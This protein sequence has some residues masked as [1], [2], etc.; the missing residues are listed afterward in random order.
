M[1]CTHV[2][3]GIECGNNEV[4]K[5]VLKRNTS[6]ERII[7][8]V[9]ILKKNKI[10]LM[11]QNL[12]GLPIPNPTKVDFDTLD[13]NIKLKPHFGWASILYPYPGTEIGSLAT[14]VGYFDGNF[15]GNLVGYFDGNFVGNFDGYWDVPKCFIPIIPFDGSSSEGDV[16][17]LMFLCSPFLIIPIST[18]SPTPNSIS[19]KSCGDLIL[20]PF[21]SVIISW[22]NYDEA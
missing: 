3:M 6:N 18:D 16:I 10:K 8:A 1:N 15:V 5:K 2:A 17:M 4:A 21:I 7:E 12:I 9:R 11:T 19:C 22:M 20:L 14:K 13:F